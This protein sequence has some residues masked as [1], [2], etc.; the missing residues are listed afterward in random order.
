MYS[1]RNA[2]R[3]LM[4]IAAGAL[5]P[6]LAFAPFLG[7]KPDTLDREKIPAEF[8]WDFSDIYI[9]ADARENAVKKTEANIAK[10]SAMKGTLKNGAES[11]LA[12][13]KLSDEIGIEIGKIRAYAALQNDADARDQAAAANMQRVVGILAAYGTASSWFSPELLTIPEETVNR[14]I[15]QTPALAP[16]R[17]Q[18]TD[19][20]RLQKHILDEQS[21]KLISYSARFAGTPQSIFRELSISDI[22]FPEITLSTGK[23]LT[24]T[25]GAYR[26]ILEQ[27]P[28]QE[29]RRLAAKTFLDAYAA[30]GNTYAAVYNSILQ[31]GLAKAQ[32][33]NYPSVLAAKLD[34]NN[35]PASVVETLLTT[36]RRGTKPLQRYMRLRQ[37]LLGL[38]E[39]HLY[40]QSTPLFEDNTKREF[41][42]AKKL[43]L[44]AVNPLGAEYREKLA[45]YLSGKRLDVY[46][47]TG[48]RSGAYNMGIEG[49]GPYVLLNYN[50]TDEAVF[51][52]AHELG[53][54]MHSILAMENQP[55]A[56]SGCTIF[57]AEVASTM[58]ER[59]LL[60]SLLRQTKDP[61]ERFLLLQKAADNIVGTFYTQTLFANYENE[62]H[63]RV[64]KG[65]PITV[66]EL[67]KIYGNLLKEYYGDAVVIDDWYARTWMRIPHFYNSPYYVYQYA[68]CFASS[69]QLYK[70]MTTGDAT[71]R[72]AALEK[73]LTLLKSGR[74]DYPM[75]QLK[76]AG[77]DL[78]KPETIQA[79]IDQMDAIVTQLEKEAELINPG[80]VKKSP[81]SGTGK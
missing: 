56:T 12:V 62:A 33:R 47:N 24:L 72:S 14:W 37:R 4:K 2:F 63:K 11:L 50:D 68:T 45:K 52:L 32:Q 39:I 28:V 42:E 49:V 26:E 38:Q 67:N 7:A 80:A 29:D 5:L 48:K 13:Q 53:H 58:N 36:A 15:A 41:A 69:A 66:D 1:N 44:D 21:E 10:F 74:N 30:T 17:F 22:K 60:D 59:F 64:E 18:I 27:S 81:P 77:V 23:K 71:S 79:V 70:D 8:K 25:P 34:G 40:D 57:V 31:A 3:T 75:E 19:A 54:S 61:K 20:Y 73:Y 51:T 65:E 35:I 6:V 9:D 16:Y 76:K 46:E 55:F 78:T 43:V